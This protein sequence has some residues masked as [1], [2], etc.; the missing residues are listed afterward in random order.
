MCC[1]KQ[2][3]RKVEKT[4]RYTKTIGVRGMACDEA[5]CTKCMLDY[6]NNGKDVNC[7]VYEMMYTEEAMEKMSK[8]A[9]THPM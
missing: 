3:L 5:N 4:R 6:H 2:L 9:E 8:W 7:A 1:W